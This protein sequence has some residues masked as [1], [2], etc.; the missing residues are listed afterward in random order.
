MKTRVTDQ[1]LKACLDTLCKLVGQGAFQDQPGYHVLNSALDVI[2]HLGGL[3][4][5]TDPS[6]YSFKNMS[7]ADDGIVAA[8]EETIKRLKAKNKNLLDNLRR[9]LS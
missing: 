5:D 3:A 8:Q 7:P 9:I 4:N 2:E 1:E 6:K